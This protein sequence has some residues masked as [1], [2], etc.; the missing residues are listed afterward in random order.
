M[1]FD[2]QFQ[3]RKLLPHPGNIK[4]FAFRALHRWCAHFCVP[5]Q[6]GGFSEQLVSHTFR[7]RCRGAACCVLWIRPLPQFSFVNDRRRI[8]IG[9]PFVA[10]CGRKPAMFSKAVIA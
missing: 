2:L 8:Q 6:T 10:S 4:S 1:A 7:G 9:S 5:P 3:R